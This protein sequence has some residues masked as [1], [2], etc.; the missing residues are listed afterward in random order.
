[1]HYP[2][3]TNISSFFIAGINYKKTDAAAR[4]QFAINNEQYELLIASAA[5]FD[6]HEFFV[7]STCNRTEIYGFAENAGQLSALLCSQTSGTLETFNERAYIHS[8]EKAI[9]HLFEVAAGLDSQILGDYEIVGQIKQS[10]KI[11]KKGNVIG[12]YLERML[13]DVLK[14]SKKI[15]TNTLLSGGTVSVS[16]A[17]V[18]FIKDKFREAVTHKKI[19]LIGVGKIGTNTCKNIADYLPGTRVV[20]LNRSVEKARELS[21][22]F[23]FGFDVM[24]NMQQCISDADI[25]LVAT[26]ANEPIITSKHIAGTQ[27]KLIIDLSV[28]CNVDEQLRLNSFVE[29]INVDELSKIKDET[30]QKRAAEVPKALEIIAAQLAEFM[31]WHEMRRHVPLLKVVKHKL[32]TIQADSIFDPGILN[33]IEDGNSKKDRIQKVIN[34]MAVKMRTQNQPGCHYIEAINDFISTAALA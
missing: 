12:A 3:V 6:I 19:L 13:N 25:V 17:A 26:N 4:G 15:R 7:L 23:N 11:A 34:G 31:E 30:L 8:G 18:Q 1:M 20:L 21:Q 9:Q 27:Q 14:T 2:G 32:L 5:Q 22:Q 28:P 10:A 24:E 29:L 16:F 33:T